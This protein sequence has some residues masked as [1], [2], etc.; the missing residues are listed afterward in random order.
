MSNILNAQTLTLICDSKEGG[1]Y[2]AGDP[3]CIP[4]NPQRILALE[5][6]ALETVLFT[7]K[8]LVG[9][10]NWLHEEVPVLMSE[11]GTDLEG[12]ADTGYPANLEAALLANRVLDDLFTYLTDSSADTPAL[13]I[14][15]AEIAL[16][17]TEESN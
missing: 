2:L 16:E 8:E 10:A 15:D 13:S 17:T 3:V 1:R 9:T 14:A 12:I 7:G 5:I 4:E 6:S 11:L